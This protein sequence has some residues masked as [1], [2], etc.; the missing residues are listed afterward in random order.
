MF[1]NMYLMLQ[2]NEHFNE[3]PEIE[4]LKGYYNKSTSTMEQW[5]KVVRKLKYKKKNV[6]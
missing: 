2:S 3:S 1:K 6:K 5:G 4:I